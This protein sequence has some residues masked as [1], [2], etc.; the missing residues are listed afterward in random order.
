MSDSASDTRSSSG[1]DLSRCASPQPFDELASGAINCNTRGNHQ[2][3]EG[4]ST[5]DDAASDES[6]STGSIKNPEDQSLYLEW[7]SGEESLEDQEDN[8]NGTD[9]DQKCRLIE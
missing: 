5:V 6:S 1:S 9:A 3:P 7:Q 4:I 8:E 2:A